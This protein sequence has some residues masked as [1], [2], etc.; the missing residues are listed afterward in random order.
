MA[1]ES[2]RYRKWAAEYLVRAQGAEDSCSRNIFTA[3]AQWVHSRAESSDRAPT[4]QQQ[5][6]IQSGKD[7]L[8]C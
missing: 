4:K 1:G 5:Q 7:K 3:L 2:E 8:D 6:Q